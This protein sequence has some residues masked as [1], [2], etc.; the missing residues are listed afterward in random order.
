MIIRSM[1]AFLM[2]ASA[3]YAAPIVGT[4]NIAGT[5]TVTPTA[6]SWT[7]DSA[8]FT[9]NKATIAGG[10]TGGFIPVQGTLATINNLNLLTEPVG[11]LFPPQPFL[12]FDAAPAFPTLNINFIFPGLFTSAQC[13]TLPA[14]VGQT[15]TPPGSLFSLTN[16]PPGPP[17]GPQGTASF[18]FSGVTSDGLENWRGNFTS[19]FTVPYQTVLASLATNGSV[20][21]TFAATF[22][23]TPAE[24]PEPST[25]AMLGIA[26]CGLSVA[27]RKFKKV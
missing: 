7:L 6:I 13:A 14:A 18:V 8:P 11:S 1:P 20:S 9:P 27:V 17:T 4:F 5:I 23:L 22:V 21:Q 12:S 16:N 26:L 25:M 19:S 24:T 2:L 15:C 10:A 3:A